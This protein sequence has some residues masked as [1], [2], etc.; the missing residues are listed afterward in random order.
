MSLNTANPSVMRVENSF[1]QLAAAAQALNHASDDLGKVIRHLDGALKK[2]ALGITAWV[3]VSGTSDDTQYWASELGYIKMDGKW[4]IALR[5]VSGYLQD[6]TDDS[7]ETWAF[8]DAPRA[9]RAQA[10]DKIPDLL[11]KML[12]M[13]ESATKDM[14]AKTDQ[15]AEITFLVSNLVPAIA[16]P[17]PQT[18]HRPASEA[19]PAVGATEG[20]AANGGSALNIRFRGG[21]AAQP[22]RP[23]APTPAP[24]AAVSPEAPASGGSPNGRLRESEGP[25]VERPGGAARVLPAERV[26]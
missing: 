5:E 19:G 9:L 3:Q 6:N 15:A 7:E 18:W 10:V 25:P 14:N 8:S 26:S 13:T 2:L 11:E 12:Q 1:K 4:C 17:A 22:E 24:V 20:K 21:N 16:A 23:A